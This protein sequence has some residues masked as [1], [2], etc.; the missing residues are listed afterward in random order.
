ML[1]EEA[2]GQM[3]VER[4]LRVTLVEVKGNG[5]GMLLSNYLLGLTATGHLGFAATAAAPENVSLLACNGAA[6][7]QSL[8]AAERLHRM[9]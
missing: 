3:A 2:T 5:L 8:K 4:R 1:D 7:R 6:Y 9:L